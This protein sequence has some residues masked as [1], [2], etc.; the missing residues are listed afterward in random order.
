VQV[1]P[2]R[3]P[4]PRDPIPD[5]ARVFEAVADKDP[6]MAQKMMRELIRLALQDIPMPGRPKKNTARQKTKVGA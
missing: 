6:A 5:H 1:G 3:P 4:L 2:A